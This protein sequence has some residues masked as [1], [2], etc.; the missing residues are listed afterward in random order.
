LDVSNNTKLMWLECCTN[1]LTNLDISKNRQLGELHCYNNQ[2]ASLDIS[3]QSDLW[4]LRC[5]MQAEGF[6]LYL[7]NEQMKE[8]TEE[9]YCDAIL[10]EKDGSI[11]EIEWLGIYPNPT[12]G[13]FFIESKLFTDEIK[14]LNLVGKVL[15]KKALNAEKT[16]IDI[17]N[18]PAGVYLV[19]TKGKIGKVV[20]N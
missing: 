7:T 2:L 12:A 11:C 18:L 13:K 16:E 20:K 9:N 10:E 5:C 14:I 8:F 17:S 15:Y 1:Q 3:S 6:I 19:I 4:V